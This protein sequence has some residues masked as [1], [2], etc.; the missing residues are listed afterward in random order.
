MNILHMVHN[1]FNR[2]RLP[3][4][5]IILLYRQFGELRAQIRCELPGVKFTHNYSLV[6]TQY[7]AGILRKRTNIVELR[8]I[9]SQFIRRGMQVT[10]R[11]PPTHKER[12]AHLRI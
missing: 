6:L 12:L 5:L 1:A 3:L 11:T 2:K 7:F 10:F 9:A 8:E 4:N